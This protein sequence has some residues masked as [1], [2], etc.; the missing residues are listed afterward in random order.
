MVTLYAV[1]SANFSL[2]KTWFTILKKKS[3]FRSTNVQYT[4][5]IQPSTQLTTGSFICFI[6]FQR[7]YTYFSFHFQ[8][9]IISKVQLTS[10]AEQDYKNL[11]WVNFNQVTIISIPHHTLPASFISPAISTS[12]AMFPFRSPFSTTSPFISF[13]PVFSAVS[14]FFS[15]FSLS[16]SCAS[17]LPF[18]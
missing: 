9:T 12:S 3:N 18:T 10:S 2:S 4:C 1:T 17:P 5:I 7:P 13:R 6:I 11:I 8:C 15:T 14:L 16:V